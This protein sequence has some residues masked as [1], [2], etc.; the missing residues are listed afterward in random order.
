MI[1]RGGIEATDTD[2]VDTARMP[3][4]QKVEPR[5]KLVQAKKGQANNKNVV[6][7]QQQVE[8]EV[9]KLQIQEY[10]FEGKNEQASKEEWLKSYRD[11]AH[12]TFE[13][14]AELYREAS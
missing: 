8:P 4:R 9:A 12:K 3:K 5:Q 10:L 14:T 2:E 13:E 1:K 11:K 6:K 7:I